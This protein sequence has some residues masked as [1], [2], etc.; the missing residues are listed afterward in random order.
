MT[1]DPAVTVKRAVKL[2]QLIL[3]RSLVVN[4]NGLIVETT[5]R[6]R[7]TGQTFSQQVSPAIDRNND[8]LIE[9]LGFASFAFALCH[10]KSPHVA[11][12]TLY[13]S[14]DR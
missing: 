1:N 7:N 3:L 12:R 11:V 13:V 10:R 6:C 5:N 8:I 9:L 4:Q 14:A 2:V